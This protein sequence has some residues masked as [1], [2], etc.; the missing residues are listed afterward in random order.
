MGGIAAGQFPGPLQ[1]QLSD[2]L[3]QAFTPATLERLLRFRLNKELHDYAPVNADFQQIVAAVIDKAVREWWIEDLILQAR[4]VLPRNPGL[5]AF[6]SSIG[7]SSVPSDRL[8]RLVNAGNQFLPVVDWRVE[9]AKLENRV[10]KAE[11]PTTAGLSSGTAFLVGRDLV[12][13]NFHVVE[14]LITR[15]TSGGVE[16][17]IAGPKQVR[18]RFDYKSVCGRVFSEGTTY[19]LADDW[20]VD[21]SPNSDKSDPREDELDYAIL[22]LDSMAADEEVGDS[23]YGGRSTR[24]FIQIPDRRHPFEPGSPIFILQH[25]KGT[26]L[27]LAFDT[28]AVQAINP[29]RTRVRYKTNTEPG[30]SGSPC[31]DQNWN[32]VALHHSGD[33]DFNPLHAPQFNEGI[34]IDAIARLLTRRGLDQLVNSGV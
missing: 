12:M 4:A 13:T 25:P 17:P 28:D 18:F 33:P 20:K 21:V 1:G 14:A 22:R 10:C 3:R 8:E 31:F 24:G 2:V 32:L 7:L 9:L 23:S 15:G 27:K 11:V 5:Y 6:A 19:G 34:P 16:D 30:S 26:P 29:R